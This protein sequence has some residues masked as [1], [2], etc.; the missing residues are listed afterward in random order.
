M[1][2]AC[3]PRMLEGPVLTT[4]GTDGERISVDY[5]ILATGCLRNRDP[6]EHICHT[7]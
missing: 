4:D 7:V 5:I 6:W 1:D 2:K 3:L